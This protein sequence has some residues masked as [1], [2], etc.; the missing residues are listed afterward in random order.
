MIS[1]AIFSLHE[2]EFGRADH[3][4]G[5]ELLNVASDTR[6]TTLPDDGANPLQ[7]TWPRVGAGLSAEDYEAQRWP[8]AIFEI[9]RS[10]TP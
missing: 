8:R 1:P 10:V 4:V 7:P 5:A 3:E 6:A 9:A 2:P